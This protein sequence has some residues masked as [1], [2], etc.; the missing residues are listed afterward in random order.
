MARMQFGLSAFERARGDLPELPV[1][2]M[3]AE[4]APTEE[5]GV[6]LQSRPGLSDRSADMGA[7]PV[8][9]LFKGDGVLTGGLYG[10]SGASLYSGATLI[11]AVDGTG[12]FSM[13]GYED[14]LLIAGGGSLWGYNGATLAAVAFPDAAN[15]SKVLVGAS[16]AIC[17]RADTEKFYWS[18]VLSTTIDALSFATAESQ[19]DRLKD[20]LF[21]DDILILFGSE[22][23]EFWPNT[24]DADLPFQPLEGRVFER[25]IKA[26][27]CATEFGATFAW[28]TN[29]NQVCMSDPDNI[30]SRPGLEA[31]IEASATVRLQTFQME[32]TE[33]L[34]LRI[35]AGDWVFSARSKLWSEFASYGSNNWLPAC[36][37]GGVFGSSQDGKTLAWGSGHLDMGGV[38]ERRFRAGFPLNAGGVMVNNIL[39]RCNVGVTGY[40]TGD[41][42]DP[43]VEMRRSLDASKTWGSWRS[44]SLGAQ[45]QYRTKVQ[46]TACGMAGQPGWLSE[47]R[48][49]DPVP[50]RVSDVRINEIFG[51][52]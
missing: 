52:I 36:F 10:V 27:G 3:F 23:V 33:F 13:A 39:L 31:L 30:I 38:L 35:D 2:N 37:A 49:T 21:I 45:G 8:Q 4:E 41:Y 24:G 32:G 48:V 51:G 46:W 7:G 34:W 11:G 19:P 16:R 1:I 28:V 5:T 26:T 20:A 43:V 6:V 47:F 14:S 18:D 17:I 40:L 22:T 9:A 15:V 25:G 42:A 44:A 29:D 12:P 50:L